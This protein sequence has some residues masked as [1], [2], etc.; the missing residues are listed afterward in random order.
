LR[1]RCI[2]KPKAAKKAKTSFVKCKQTDENC[3]PGK[4]SARS[5]LVSLKACQSEKK[6]WFEFHRESKIVNQ[7]GYP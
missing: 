2:C 1:G 5:K 7:F 3:A 4:A 6:K